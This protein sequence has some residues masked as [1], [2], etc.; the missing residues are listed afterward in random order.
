M[1]AVNIGLKEIVIGSA[2]LDKNLI[3]EA[4][5]AITYIYRRGH[6]DQEFPFGSQKSCNKMSVDFGRNSDKTIG[7][8][9][10][11]SIVILYLQVTRNSPSN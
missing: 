11:R 5:Q 6:G 3:V 10:S 7:M 2:K 4:N 8:N 9:P 1:S